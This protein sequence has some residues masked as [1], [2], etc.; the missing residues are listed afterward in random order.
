MA[1]S[2]RDAAEQ[3]NL[4]KDRF[5]AVISHELRTP[6]TPALAA[7]SELEG[8]ARLPADVREDVQT[9]RRNIEIEARLVNDLL[10]LAKAEA[11]RVEPVYAPAGPA[12][13][14]D[15]HRS[16]P[17]HRPRGT[18][19]PAAGRRGGTIR[20]WRGRGGRG[21]GARPRASPR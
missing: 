8:D 11:G 4:A 18:V 16:P 19:P 12:A 6:L 13:A 15:R 2:A 21:R 9:I 14:G 5:I 10:D 17:C 3:S 7:A 20:S 1:P